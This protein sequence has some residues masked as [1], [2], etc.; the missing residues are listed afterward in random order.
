VSSY[1]LHQRI[2]YY[3]VGHINLNS[4]MYNGTLLSNSLLTSVRRR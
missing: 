3:T 2:T 4:V 1:S